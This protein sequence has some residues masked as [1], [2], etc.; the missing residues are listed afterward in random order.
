MG[1]ENAIN[2]ILD[3]ICVKEVFNMY[4]VRKKRYLGVSL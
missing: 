3:F 1:V 2:K 4:I